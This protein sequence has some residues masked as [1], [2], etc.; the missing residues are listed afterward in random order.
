MEKKDIRMKRCNELLSNIRI[1]KLYNWENKLIRESNV[2][3][4]SG[5]IKEQKMYFACRL[6]II[7]FISWG[8]QNYLAVG[9]VIT[10]AL[11]GVTLT[12]TN[13]FAGL[14]VIRVLKNSMYML[15]NIVNT[16]IQTKISLTRI[17]DYLRSK[18]QGQYLQAMYGTRAIALNNASFAWEAPEPV[19]KGELAETKTVAEGHKPRGNGRGAD[20]CGGQGGIRQV[21]VI[22]GDLFKT[23][24]LSKAPK[25]LL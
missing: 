19:S 10:M 1:F 21:F 8:A 11:T 15:P 17:Q 12:P 16:F 2:S 23:C 14:S 4:K 6:L 24:T 9:V 25:T 22:A 3:E 20:R 18:D 5:T 13:V 7:F